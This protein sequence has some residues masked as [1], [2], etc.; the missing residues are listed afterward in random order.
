MSFYQILASNKNGK[1]EKSYKNKKHRISALTWDDKIELPGGLYSVLDNQDYFG[2]I[3][4][5][6]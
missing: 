3:I 4:K 5:K 1:Y 6:Q 2:Y